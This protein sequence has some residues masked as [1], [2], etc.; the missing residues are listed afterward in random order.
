[1]GRKYIIASYLNENKGKAVILYVHDITI[2]R[3]LSSLSV[4]QDKYVTL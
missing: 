3:N 4:Y 1:V 2:Y